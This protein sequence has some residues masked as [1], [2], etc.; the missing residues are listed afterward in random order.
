M[1]PRGGLSREE[2][3]RLDQVR[4]HTDPDN[5]TWTSVY[6]LRGRV[7]EKEDPTAGN[8][9]MAYDPN[10]NLVQSEDSRSKYISYVYDKLGRT[11]A[12]YA[13]QNVAADQTAGPS[14]TQM[15]QWYYDNS[16]HAI[17]GMTNPIGQLTT[18]TTY[19]NG[20]TY[21]EQTAGF[22]IFGESLGE[23]IIIPSTVTGLAGTYT[24]THTYTTYTGLPFKDTYSSFGGINSETTEHS[25]SGLFDSPSELADANY[26]YAQYVDYDAY[27]RP[28]QEQIG[29][30]TGT[31]EITNT[32][33]V[34]TGSLH[35]QNI[36]RQTATPTAVDDTVY[37]DDPSGNITQQTETRL[38]SSSDTETQCYQYNGLDQLN[39]AWS[40]TAACTTAPTASNVANTLGT[41]SAY[42]DSWTFNNEGDRTG[43]TQYAIGTATT[44]TTT[45]YT[46]SSSQPHTLASTSTTGGTTANT[47]Y[48]YDTAGNTTGRTT[49]TDGTQTL[50]WNNA[51]QLASVNTTT[52][53]TANT[54]GTSSYVYDPSGKLLLQITPTATTVYFENEQATHSTSNGAVTGIRY[55]ALPGG[56][57][58]V[59]TG[60]TTNYTFEITDQHGTADLDLD[61][62]CQTPTWRQYDPY[63]NSRGATATWV[64]NRGFL[65]DVNDTSTG[66]TDIGAR[67]YDASLGRFASLDPVFEAWDTLALGGYTYT[68][69]NPVGEADPTGLMLP[70]GKAASDGCTTQAQCNSDVVQYNKEVLRNAITEAGWDEQTEWHAR[71][72][73]AQYR[74]GGISTDTNCG[75]L[76]WQQEHEI[77]YKYTQQLELLQNEL[78]KIDNTLWPG[79]AGCINGNQNG[80]CVPAVATGIT[81]AS[82]AA[83]DDGTNAPA[84]GG[85]SF[86]ADTKVLTSTG[87]TVPITS[88]K[89]GD[90]VISANTTTGKNQAETVDAVLVHHDTNLYNLTVETGHGIEVIHATANHLIWDLTQHAWIQ[91]SKIHKGDR[92]LTENG[93]TAT[94]DGG[95][96][97]ADQTGWMWDLTVHDLHAFYVLAGNTPVLVH[98][99]GGAA[100]CLIGQQGEAASGITKNTRT[101]IINGRPRIP[102][103]LDPA[104]GIIGEVKNVK[105]Q[106]LS[107]QLKD[108]LSYA[109]ANGFQFNLYVNSATQLS[110]PL[111]SLVDSGQINLIRNI[112]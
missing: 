99:A 29:G 66:I 5:E 28:T 75:T 51:E 8:S 110:S 90:K 54:A 111:Q 64:D 50:N 20:A 24:I 84:C 103:E 1:R 49:P 15:Y 37:T 104:A 95:S 82:G 13:A 81:F 91:A 72:I 58:A 53:G 106:Y 21:T 47:S 59:R 45:T 42:W 3:D 77:Q 76:S 105:Y 18:Q 44:N 108:D 92:L 96:A 62:T 2:A 86:T 32:Y 14:G 94:V 89:V 43:Q 23:E 40:A 83:E 109:Q 33:D 11:T 87:K 7:T 73:A 78:L 9:F 38:G 10:G 93:A 56:G 12:E 61:Y 60:N 48:G 68:D 39:Q 4:G 26:G 107:T 70:Y 52:A 35:E 57:T 74:C 46:Y 69:G 102:D 88:L 112:P 36:S 34:H 80:D 85:D 98:N 101:I 100:N 63:G 6:D 30:S 67:W 27:S 22:N 25:Y 31:A 16:N 97:P 79:L 55:L 65:N 71:K 17:S 41:G 19:A